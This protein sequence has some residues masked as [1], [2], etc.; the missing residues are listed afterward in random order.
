MDP[1][2]RKLL[3][4]VQLDQLNPISWNLGIPNLINRHMNYSNHSFFTWSS[5]VTLDW[6][7]WPIS[8][9]SCYFSVTYNKQFLPQEGPNRPNCGGHQI[10]GAAGVKN[11][12]VNRNL[13]LLKG[14]LRQGLKNGRCSLSKHILGIT[15]L[16]WDHKRLCFPEPAQEKYGK[17][18]TAWNV[19]KQKK[20]Q[21]SAM[22]F[23]SP[24]MW[25][26]QSRK[27]EHSSR[28]LRPFQWC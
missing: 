28:A 22:R 24:S 13:K 14:T 8:A 18:M 23:K 27:W 3:S 19:P 12:F 11:D 10:D 15:W 1:H 5:H 2:N 25:W 20:R 7:C 17:G 6:R 16:C 26:C 21:C 9:D 4:S